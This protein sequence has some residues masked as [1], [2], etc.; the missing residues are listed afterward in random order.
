MTLLLLGLILFL[1][2]H[3]VRIFAEGWRTAMVG[4][5]GANGWK[6]LYSVVSLV[7][8]ALVVVGF[9]A[10]RA[11]PQLVWV[12]PVALRH[13]AALL[14]LVAFVM[15][16]AAYVPG[17]FIKARLRH[18]MVLGVKVWAL[19]HLVSNQMLGEMVLF[20]AFLVWAV[21]DFRAAR[22]RDRASGEAP[23]AGRVG[24]TIVTVV[25]GVV[26]WAVFAVWVH[27]ALIGVK[28]F[29]G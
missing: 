23:P 2:A 10:T 3:S 25:V 24:P 12:P 21:L 26:G 16:V 15:I 4:R 7:G 27:G 11:Q 9:G 20:G 6:G 22:A 1:G 29:G 5:L 8:L 13:V 19:A 18:P 17:N 14:N 28:P